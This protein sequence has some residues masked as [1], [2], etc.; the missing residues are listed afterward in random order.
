MTPRRV[1]TF[2]VIVYCRM[3]RVSVVRFCPEIGVHAIDRGPETC[4]HQTSFCKLYC[5]NIPIY[6]FRRKRMEIRDAVNREN[7]NALT[8][9]DLCAELSRKKQKV[10]RLRLCTRGEAFSRFIDTGKIY[11]LLCYNPHVL[12]WIP[13]RGWHDSRIRSSIENDILTCANARVLAS[14]DP[15]DSQDVIDD[16]KACGWSTVRIGS[17]DPQEGRYR[18]PKTFEHKSGHCAV[19][20]Q[21]CFSKSRV[22]VHLQLHW[23]GRLPAF[24]D[25]CTKKLF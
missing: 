13:T 3:R 15:S 5:Y 9:S 11:D 2:L 1:C 7:W 24:R 4:R 25:W 10:T 8:G 20:M 17:C 18:C 21:G 23:A 16:L 14:V 19:C 6:N 12:F 22:D